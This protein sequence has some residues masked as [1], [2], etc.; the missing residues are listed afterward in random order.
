MKRLFASCLLAAHFLA[1]PVQAQTPQPDPEIDS[2]TRGAVVRSLGEELRKTYVFA[3]VADRVS[4]EL[5]S[6]ERARAYEGAKTARAFAE[7]LNADLQELGK[8][9]HFRIT[10]AP[11]FVAPA[12]DDAALT[13]ERLSELKVR[14][15][16]TGYGIRRVS[17]LPG[18]IGYLDVTGFGTP[19]FVA[20]AY[21]AAMQLLAGSDA[22]IVDLRDNG[23]GDPQSVVQL[24]SHFF[25]AGDARHLNSIYTR[26]TDTTREYWTDRSVAT[27]F[28]GP[29]FLVTSSRTFSGGEGF[30]Y[31]LQT[32][33]RATVIGETT[34]GGANPGG[35][36]KLAGGFAAFIPNGRAINPVTGTNW[37]HVGV[38]P[39]VQVGAQEALAN[40]YE[41][42]LAASMER[43]ANPGRK[44][45]YAGV[46][47]RAKAGDVPLPEW[48]PRA[49]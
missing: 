40:A 30:A 10:Y 16:Q 34:G 25:A 18:N 14:A 2:A 48:K 44:A 43:E 32:Q 19:E 6:K 22:I 29:V 41:A 24:A 1:V 21:E 35:T 4:K 49:R 7:M 23:G 46:I 33:K 31:E 38:K 15:E 17:R 47:E 9:R 45:A 42:A 37:E 39:D 36:V 27:R 12:A 11:D 3:D 8:D 20:P 5:S 13:A 26:P 28:T